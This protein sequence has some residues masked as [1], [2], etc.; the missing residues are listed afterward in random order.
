MTTPTEVPET[1]A[2]AGAT[3]ATRNRGQ[4]LGA[5][6]FDAAWKLIREAGDHPAAESYEWLTRL[7]AVIAEKPEKN[8]APAMG[9][10]GHGGGGMGDMGF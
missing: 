2:S 1:L 10:H 5:P 8:P 6:D 7:N 3:P 9:G 4:F